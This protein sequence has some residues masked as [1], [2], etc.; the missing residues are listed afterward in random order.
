MAIQK[1]T[2]LSS[3]LIGLIYDAASDPR[4]WPALLRSLVNELNQLGFEDIQQSNVIEILTSR[5]TNRVDSRVVAMDTL[6]LPLEIESF[7][8]TL[9]SHLDRAVGIASQVEK[10]QTLNNLASSAFN[11]IPVPA[12]LVDKNANII[13]RSHL[14]DALLEEL[15]YVEIHNQQLVC[16]RPHIDRAL[17]NVIS[18]AADISAKSNNTASIR[19]LRQV[20]EHAVSILV[21]P[22]ESEQ[23]ATA[24]HNDQ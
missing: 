1:Q 19:L 9:S 16:T 4:Q 17:K 15:S 18:K 21:T 7:L 8:S 24:N 13:M 20:A 14:F 22:L 2:Q 10:S 23:Q 11:N 3:D 5:D 12:L 6:C